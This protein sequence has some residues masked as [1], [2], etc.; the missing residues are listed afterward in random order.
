M[1]KVPE[2]D[3]LKKFHGW[4]GYFTGSNRHTHQQINTYHSIING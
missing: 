2:T 1:I 3:H 4:L